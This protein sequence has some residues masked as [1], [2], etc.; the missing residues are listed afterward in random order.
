MY[1]LQNVFSHAIFRT[2]GIMSWSPFLFYVHDRR[3]YLVS[4]DKIQEL[5]APLKT[6]KTSRSRLPLRDLFEKSVF[7]ISVKRYFV[8]AKNGI[9][10]ILWYFGVA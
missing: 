7:Q 10:V 8:Y 9:C 3:T 4:G 5:L 6:H 2:A 1:N